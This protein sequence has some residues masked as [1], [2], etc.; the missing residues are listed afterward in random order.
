MAAAVKWSF[1]CRA[2]R[3]REE[4]DVSVEDPEE[5]ATTLQCPQCGYLNV[6]ARIRK[7]V[8]LLEAM[9]AISPD[10]HEQLRE[11][12]ASGPA[13]EDHLLRIFRRGVFLLVSHIASL[14]E[15]QRAAAQAAL[16]IAILERE[17]ELA[18]FY[19][20]RQSGQ[21]PAIDHRLKLLGS[22]RTVPRT[23]DLLY[24]LLCVNESVHL[25]E[26]SPD[27]YDLGVQFVRKF[28]PFATDAVSLAL[29]ISRVEM[30]TCT[31]TLQGNDVLAVDTDLNAPLIEW[32]LNKSRAERDA[33][34][35]TT[36]AETLLPPEMQEAMRLVL[37]FDLFDIVE[38]VR[39]GFVGL[40]RR[41][42]IQDY[43][44][45]AVWLL[46]VEH[47]EGARRVLEFLTLTWARVLRFIA[48]FHFDLGVQR[49]SPGEQVAVLTQFLFDNWW[50]YYP[51]YVVIG[52]DG[53]RKC[54]L[55]KYTLAAF[56]DHLTSVKGTLFRRIIDNLG[57]FGV[58]RRTQVHLKA[59]ELRIHRRLEEET[60]KAARAH[61]WSALVRLR[62]KDGLMLPCGEIDVI[63]AKQF[64]DGTLAVVADVKDW[65]I[66]LLGK[67]DAVHKFEQRIRRA[68]DRLAEK[69][70][71]VW[72]EWNRGLSKMVD[73]TLGPGALR[74]VPVLFTSN[75]LPMHM[76]GNYRAVLVDSVGRFV[77]ELEGAWP[78]ALE[79]VAGPKL[80]QAPGQ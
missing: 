19:S 52:P 24:L 25:P 60:A 35:P 43:Y 78:N 44:S 20:S 1:H 36:F 70:R 38:L 53:N 11:E 33:T 40:Q 8:A 30:G 13:T 41:G 46:D 5:F 79:R 74:V 32:D 39:G 18:T 4:R 9:R 23:V 37:G 64:G 45:E 2:C 3:H 50:I 65:D 15:S 80:L 27:N 10:T 12:I 59:L 47:A 31:L 55:S 77:S 7:P 66:P 62:K 22:M 68:T 54:L 34:P 6:F 48:P 76:L 17:R 57:R 26:P 63:M 75:Y 42:L 72:S 58:D 51:G 16:P 49:F 28:S 61:G 29:Y 69:A 73:P 67:R 14:V 71:W 21:P 56:Y